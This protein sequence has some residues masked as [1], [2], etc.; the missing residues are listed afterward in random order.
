VATP[1]IQ[2]ILRRDLPLHDTRHKAEPSAKSGATHD[3][4]KVAAVQEQLLLEIS[5]S[6]LTG[7]LATTRGALQVLQGVSGL[8]LASYTTLLAA[9]GRQFHASQIPTALLASPIAFYILSLLA[10]F[11]EVLFYR[12]SR[13]TL[14]DL[15]SGIDAY[16]TVVSAQRRQLILP[17]LFLLAGVT[18][19]VI[20]TVKL[21]RLP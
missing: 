13:I 18:A 7:T 1:S 17:L 9:F 19:V 12:G 14:G 2:K 8:L 6:L 3:P 20:I 15:E 21:L 5:K 10:G 11:G 16:E 4:S